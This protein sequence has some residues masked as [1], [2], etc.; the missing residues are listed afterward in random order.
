M[1]S[2]EKVS[3]G[4]LKEVVGDLKTILASFS[5]LSKLHNENSLHNGLKVRK[6]RPGSQG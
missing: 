6:S 3:R 4:S 1:I 5:A 2:Y